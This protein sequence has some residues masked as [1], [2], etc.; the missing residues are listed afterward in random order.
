MQPLLNKKL[1]TTR[2]LLN[3]ELNK[4]RTEMPRGRLLR[5]KWL[6]RLPSSEQL[7]LPRDRRTPNSDLLS[8]PLELNAEP[9][10]LS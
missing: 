1:L 8:K 6:L 2:L 7:L 10:E 9:R 4:K 3:L 5:S